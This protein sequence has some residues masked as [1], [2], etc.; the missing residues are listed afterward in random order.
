ML[1]ASR[2][3]SEKYYGMYSRWFVISDQGFQDGI[4]E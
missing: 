3:S 2:F 1:N 4:T